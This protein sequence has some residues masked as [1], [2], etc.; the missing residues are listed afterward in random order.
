MAAA[1]RRGFIALSYREFKGVMVRYNRS[2]K[3]SPRRKGDEFFNYAIAATGIIR[4]SRSS[5][6]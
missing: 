4:P 6:V 1:W 2:K 5:T 3:K